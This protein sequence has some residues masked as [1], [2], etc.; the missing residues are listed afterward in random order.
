MLLRLHDVH[1]RYFPRLWI[2]LNID[3]KKFGNHQLLVQIL[4]EDLFFSLISEIRVVSDDNSRISLFNTIESSSLITFLTFLLEEFSVNTSVASLVRLNRIGFQLEIP[5]PSLLP[6][7][8]LY[9]PYPRLDPGRK[10]L[11]N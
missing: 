8:L 2:F 5:F 1:Y 7:P 9:H 6:R 4:C 11:V 10:F 3:R